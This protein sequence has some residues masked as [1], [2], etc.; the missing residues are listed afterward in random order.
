M[1]LVILINGELHK[2]G[3]AKT[4]SKTGS[5]PWWIT[6]ARGS[7]RNVEVWETLA[8]RSVLLYPGRKHDA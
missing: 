5:L 2:Q 7:S 6:F 1:H 4:G 8:N 3:N